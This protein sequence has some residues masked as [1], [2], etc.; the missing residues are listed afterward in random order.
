MAI[1]I[2]PFV[3]PGIAGVRCAFQVRDPHDADPFAGNISLS[4]GTDRDQTVRNRRDLAAACNVDGLADMRQV[5]GDR[6]VFEP[7][8]MDAGTDPEQ[9]GD[10]MVTSRP[11]LGLMIKTADCQPLLL[12]HAS[13][14]YVAALHVGWRGNRIGYPGAG[15]RDFCSRCGLDPAEISA[16]RGPSLGPA[17]AEFVNFAAEWGPEFLPWFDA[18]RQTM[19]LWRLTR[20]Q[21]ETAGLLPERIFSLDLCTYSLPDFLFSYRR[22]ANCGRQGSLIWIQ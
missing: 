17:A 10:G 15:V 2:I 18:A 8:S 12:A 5:H 7:G 22:D 9:E 4:T 6:T 19:D 21:L 3:F 1:N 16:V 11:G 14:R 13:G 20:C